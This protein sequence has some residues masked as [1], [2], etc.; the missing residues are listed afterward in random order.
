MAWKLDS[1]STHQQ[2]IDLTRV[3]CQAGLILCSVFWNIFISD[4]DEGVKGIFMKAIIGQMLDIITYS[5][6]KRNK[7]KMILIG[8]RNESK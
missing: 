5:R 1:R 8:Y 4:L 7:S 3:R 2:I 6:N